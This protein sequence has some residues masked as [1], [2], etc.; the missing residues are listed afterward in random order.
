MQSVIE[1]VRRIEDH[2]ACRDAAAVISPRSLAC[3]CVRDRRLSLSKPKRYLPFCAIED[4][5]Q[6]PQSPTFNAIVRDDCF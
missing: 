5:Y 3:V 2:W 6:I 1:G 4:L